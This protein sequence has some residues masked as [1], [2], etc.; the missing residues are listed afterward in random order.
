MTPQERKIETKG[1][2]VEAAIAN[3]L[4]ELNLERSEVEV[5]IV[6]SGSSGFLG[7][8][9]KEA[10]VI[11]TA[12]AGAGGDETV[13]SL[14][15][16]IETR[17]ITP[18]EP[19]VEEA[20][21]VIEDIAAIAGDEDIVDDRR[22]EVVALEIIENLLERLKF[23]V[24]TSVTQT[25]PDDLTGERRWVIEI[26]GED[27]GMLIGNRGETLNALQHVSRLMTGHSMHQRPK[28]IVD[29]QGYR[30]RRE[31]ALARLAE[32]MA[33]KVADQG[34]PMTLEPMPPNERRIIHITLRD[35][36][37][38]YTESTGDGRHR[39]VRIFPAE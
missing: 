18:Q 30:A 25:E 22:E 32:R 9:G 8:G 2:D 14:S 15:P 6:D 7:I 39:K 31:Q 36:D 19:P 1:T 4:K 34:N 13:G 27:M 16:E 11:L 29:V 10:V 17:D 26:T 35:D 28:F 21:E 5:E 33:D 12:S 3:G 37:R 38:V 20:E 24:S 23:E